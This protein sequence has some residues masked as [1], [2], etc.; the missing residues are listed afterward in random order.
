LDTQPSIEIEYLEIALQ[1]IRAEVDLVRD[2]LARRGLSLGPLRTTR[3]FAGLIEME[4]EAFE[5]G[6]LCDILEAAVWK[7]GAP[8]EP[9]A[10]LV[11]YFRRELPTLGLLTQDET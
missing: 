4:I 3:H 10:D 6:N 11:A 8:S 5:E 9:L 2:A 1:A 7:D